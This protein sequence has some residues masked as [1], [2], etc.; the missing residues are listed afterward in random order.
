MAIEMPVS[1]STHCGWAHHQSPV[2]DAVDLPAAPPPGMPLTNPLAALPWQTA[3]AVA[4][5]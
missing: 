1:F 2:P 5:V 4:E 3:N